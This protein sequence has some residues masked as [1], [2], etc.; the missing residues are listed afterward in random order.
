VN[1]FQTFDDFVKDK[2]LDIAMISQLLEEDYLRE[3]TTLWQNH[4]VV[5]F[6]EHIG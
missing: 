2:R 4:G 5:G 3:P 1:L 6:R